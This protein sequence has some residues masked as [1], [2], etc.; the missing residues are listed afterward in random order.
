MK[1]SSQSAVKATSEVAGTDTVSA[2]IAHSVR[3]TVE[4]IT[5][6]V[7][8]QM[9]ERNTSNRPLS[10]SLARRYASDMAA[11]RWEY[12]GQDILFT[13]DGDLLDGQHRLTGV[14]IAGVPVLMG[15]K[16][17][18]PGAVFD[19]IDAGRG[20]TASDVLALR[21]V[22]HYAAVASASRLALLYSQG[23]Q[24]NDSV[25]TRRE[26][27]DHVLARPYLI[28]AT[29]LARIVSGRLNPSPVAAVIFLANEGRLFD[30]HMAEFLEGVSGGAGLERAD[31]R[32]TLREWA[33][34]E[35]MRNRGVL[36]TSSC[37]AAFARAWNAFARNE[38]LKQI[39]ILRKPSRETMEI[40]GFRTQRAA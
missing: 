27:T 20:R 18:L 22:P 24:L 30:D 19:T 35:R 12:N 17:G 11:G 28:E 2:M 34:T 8:A 29:K 3:S 23:R 32:L 1:A 6:E 13:D 38:D 15:V 4:L 26:I 16:R 9:L 14:T 25:L 21:G 10:N 7:A 33:V 31:P 40:V 39:K 5:P 37:F 36:P